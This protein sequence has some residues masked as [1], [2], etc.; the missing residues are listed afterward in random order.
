[1]SQY[2]STVPSVV[3][4]NGYYAG[5]WHGFAQSLHVAPARAQVEALA[6]E[7]AR[8]DADVRRA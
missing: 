7:A 5:L 1:V 8:L 6:D 3:C 4:E 2:R